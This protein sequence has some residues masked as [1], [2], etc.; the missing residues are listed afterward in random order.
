MGN[1]TDGNFKENN[2]ARTIAI[3][4]TLARLHNFCLEEV[5]PNQLEIDM[6]NISNE[7]EGYVALE[8]SNDHRISM[9]TSL[10]DVGHHF[11]DVP[12][13]A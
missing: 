10:M 3:V 12:R 5:I 4:N 11:G 1:I 6:E 8:D 13:I 9:P 2:S 7:E